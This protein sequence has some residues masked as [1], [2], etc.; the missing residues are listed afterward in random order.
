MSVIT[1]C[2]PD[3]SERKKEYEELILKTIDTDSIIKIYI[4]SSKTRKH[5]HKWAETNKLFHVSYC[6]KK[7]S[8]ETK[9]SYWCETCKRYIK[10]KDYEIQYCCRDGQCGEYL[11]IC[12]RCYFINDDDDHMS[13]IADESGAYDDVPEKKTRRTNNIIAISNKIE[14]LS[15]IFEKKKIKNPLEWIKKREKIFI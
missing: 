6:D 14:M 4:E 15:D 5:F 2:H 12:N 1:Y 3:S 8:F 11:I 7:M 13:I 9:T 10:E